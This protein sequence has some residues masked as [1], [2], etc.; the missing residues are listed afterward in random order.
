MQV[1]EISGFLRE[2]DENC[3]LQGYY[4][5]CSGNSLLTFRENL[6]VSKRR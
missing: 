3:A 6:A 2:V 1:C 5:E 4:A